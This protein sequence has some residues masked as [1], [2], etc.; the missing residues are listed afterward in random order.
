MDLQ[1]HGLPLSAALPECD[2]D[3]FELVARLVDR[4]EAIRPGAD[5]PRGFLGDGSAEQRRRLSGRV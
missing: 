5:P 3:A 1:D 2:D 4:C